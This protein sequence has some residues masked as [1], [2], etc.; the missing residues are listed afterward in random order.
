MDWTIVSAFIHLERPIKL[1]SA[2]TFF[3]MDAS[4][5]TM[6]VGLDI[7]LNFYYFSLC[8][9]LIWLDDPYSC[10]LTVEIT[11]TNKQMSKHLIQLHKFKQKNQYIF[12][13]GN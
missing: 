11:Q 13:A 2:N 10:A 6:E 4:W 9:D 5:N 7:Y 3:G 12:L 1:T 8:L